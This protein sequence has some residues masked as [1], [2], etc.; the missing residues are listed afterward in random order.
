MV[1]IL[2]VLAGVLLATIAG[3]QT[4]HDLKERDHEQLV[5][6]E[7]QAIGKRHLD[8]GLWARDIGI[9]PQATTQILRADAAS[10][11][12]HPG[13]RTVLNVMRG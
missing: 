9:V 7:L 2:P 6:N 11:G 1:R 8:I 10:Q 12:K 13:A 4:R 3:A 5:L